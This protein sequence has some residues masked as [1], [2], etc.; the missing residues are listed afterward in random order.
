MG[1]RAIG[2]AGGPAKCSLVVDELGFDACVDY[3]SDGFAEDLTAACPKGVD[4]YFEN[5][6]GKVLEAVLP[7]LNPF[8]RVPVCGLIAHYNG[9]WLPRGANRVPLL[10]RA[11]LIKRLSFRGFIVYDF[12][13]QQAQ[14][15]IDMTQWL[16]EGKV[17]YREDIVDG[18]ENAVAAFK[19]LFT[20]QNFGKLIVRVGPE[21]NRQ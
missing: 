11:I 8:G 15:E 2:I 6:G 5:V 14:F 18:L 1:C 9:G 12:H 16:R 20:G 19:R 13:E 4:V 17:K 7:L 3:R 21:P 10:M